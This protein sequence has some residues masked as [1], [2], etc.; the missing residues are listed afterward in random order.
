MTQW[1]AITAA[2]TRAQSGETDGAA[3]LM[4]QWRATTAD[5]HAYR[6]ILAHYLAD[7]QSDVRDELEWDRR[8]LAEHAGVTDAALQPLGI[9]SARGFLPSLHLNVAD[10]LR[11]DDSPADARAHLAEASAALDALDD[12]P[13][14][15]LIRRALGEL[16][17]KLDGE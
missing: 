3:A 15:N 2:I 16:A 7:T 5:Q 4:A 1:E 9:A 8:A 6:C 10:A 12:S 13:Y 14:S 17:T 11:R